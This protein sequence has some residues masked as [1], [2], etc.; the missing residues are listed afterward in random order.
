VNEATDETLLRRQGIFNPEMVR[1]LV[2]RFRKDGGWRDCILL[3][4]IIMFQ[5]W[6]IVVY[7]N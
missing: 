4:S 6:Y 1:V 7:E 3:W 5:M 2:D